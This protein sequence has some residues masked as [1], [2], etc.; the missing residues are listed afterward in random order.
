[1]AIW[2]HYYT[3]YAQP[4]KQ[5]LVLPDL[6]LQLHVTT[7][8]PAPNLI[9]SVRPR[10]TLVR[11]IE[12]ILWRNSVHFLKRPETHVLRRIDHIIIRRSRSAIM[13]ETVNDTELQINFRHT[14]ETII[15]RGG[16]RMSV[17]QRGTNA[18]L[19]YVHV[20]KRIS[21]P[22]LLREILCEVYIKRQ[23]LRSV[24]D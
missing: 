16:K 10:L 14:Q 8:V 3:L 21:S 12:V 20:R 7:V 15:F 24:N 2:L 9:S 6:V 19:R 18:R 22:R 13:Q 23:Y 17:L 4:F 1:M 5:H 11:D